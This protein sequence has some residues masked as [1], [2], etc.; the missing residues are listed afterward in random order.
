[1]SSAY[2]FEWCLRAQMLVSVCACV[3]RIGRMLLTCQNLSGRT[4]IANQYPQT[5]DHSFNHQFFFLLFFFWQFSHVLS[6]SCHSPKGPGW[7]YLHVGE[8]RSGEHAD[9]AALFSNLCEE[10]SLSCWH[11]HSLGAH[12]QKKWG[13]RINGML[14]FQRSASDCVWPP[15]GSDHAGQWRCPQP[16]LVGPTGPQCHLHEDTL[17]GADGFRKGCVPWCRHFSELLV[18]VAVEFA[19]YI[20]RLYIYMPSLFEAML[21]VKNI[22]RQNNTPNKK[23]NRGRGLWMEKRGMRVFCILSCS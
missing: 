1:M 7:S 5:R 2:T 16:V 19:I 23:L 18:T 15:G 21:I 12:F 13:F 14:H 9:I 10:Q 3:W 20:F 17:L 8:K 11:V 4:W 22:L 6:V